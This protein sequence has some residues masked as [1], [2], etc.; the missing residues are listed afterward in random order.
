M[1]VPA[2]LA[3]SFQYKETALITDMN[4][5]ITTFRDE[6]MNRNDPAWSEPSAA[7]FK[8]PPDARGRW[9]DVLLTRISATNLE[10]RVRNS[11]GV[12]IETGRIQMDAGGNIFR[13]FTGQFYFHIE[14]IR[15]QAECA[16]GGI[17]DLSPEAQD[18]HTQ[19]AYAASYRT[20]ADAVQGFPSFM[21]LAVIDNATPARVTRIQP[22]IAYGEATIGT[23]SPSGGFIFTAA[24]VL[25]KAPGGSEFVFGGRMYQH[26]V[27]DG[28]LAPG[29]EI[30]VPIDAGSY[31]TFKVSGLSSQN[32]LRVAL[33]IG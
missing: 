28:D 32:S 18:I 27:C 2:Y 6:V 13:F 29:S 20:V 19:W 26:M 21:G 9:I 15:S 24:N 22:M 7:L 3:S 8:S 10:C 16:R 14:S 25:M 4:D 12:T 11:S 5:A 23:K 33:R 31:G 17:L 1:A 30:V